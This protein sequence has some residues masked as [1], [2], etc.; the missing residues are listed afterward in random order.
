M[1]TVGQ[2]I[3]HLSCL[4]PDVPV[5][6]VDIDRHPRS[7]RATISLRAVVDSDTVHDH[8][9]GQPRAVWLSAQPLDNGGALERAQ[10]TTIVLPR[11]PC[12]CLIPVMLQSQ[13][14]VNLDAFACPH[15]QPSDLIVRSARPRP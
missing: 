10:P 5:G 3:Q 2:L 14:S 4:D 7:Q 6:I 11:H 12:G 8:H 9:T 13:R 15:H 1:L